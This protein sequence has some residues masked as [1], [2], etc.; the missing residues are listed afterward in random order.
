MS[1]KKPRGAHVSV[2][3]T[4]NFYLDLLEEAT[5]GKDLE[6]RDKWPE[7]GTPTKG[8]SVLAQTA[9]RT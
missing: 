7:S 3:E 4:K 2:E 9:K 1:S 5:V 6:T 8:A